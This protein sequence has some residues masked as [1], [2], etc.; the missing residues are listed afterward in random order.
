MLKLY[1]FGGL[2]IE[3]DGRPLQL[4]TQ[5]AGALLAYLAAFR[6]RPHPRSV[7][8]G[9]LWPKVDESKARRRLSDTLWRIRHV[10]GDYVLANDERIWLNLDLPCWLDVEQ[11]QSAV[12]KLKPESSDP[13]L[14]ERALALYRG[15]FLD[16]VY[17]DWAL[18][19]QERLRGLYLEALGHLLTHHKRVGDYT[20][21]LGVARRLV[22]TEPLHETAHRE[23]MRLYH[24]LGRDAEAVAQ[25]RR[26]QE[27]LQQE[28]GVSPAPETEKL[29]RTLSRRAHPPAAAPEAHLPTPALSPAPSLDEPPLVG[30]EAERAALLSRLEAA[31]SGQGGILLLEGEPGVGKSRLAQ[32]LVAGARWRNIEVVLP[33]ADEKTAPAY[34]LLLG[35]LSPLL[36]PLRIRQLTR[37]VEPVHLQALAPLFP[38]LAETLSVSSPLPELPPPQARERI[39]QAL[40]ALVLGL[41]Q[42]KPCLWVLEDV[43]DADA[44]TL[45]LL[46]H[47]LPALKRSRTFVLLTGRSAE[48]RAAPVVWETLQ[49]LDRAGPFPR[50]TLARLDEDAIGRLVRNLLGDEDAILTEHL[51]HESDGV[52]LYLVETLKAWRDEGYLLPGESGTW[53]WSGD[54]PAVPPSHL[55]EAVIAHRLSRLSPASEQVLASAAV[56]GAEVDFDL[57][58]R[59]CAL[60]GRGPDM[61][62]TDP[63][64]LA[65]DELLSLGFLGE[66]NI[67]YRFSHEQVRQAVY[68]SLPPSQ[69]QRLHRRVALAVEE[70]G[71]ERFELLAHHFAAAGQRKPA[72]HY[73]TRAAE[74]ARALFAH[75]NALSCYDRLLDLLTYAEDRAARYDVLCDR[76][77]ALGWIGDREAQGRDL[78]EMLGLARAL[79]D[80]ARLAETLHRR[81]EWRRMQ[82]RYAPANEDALAALEIYRRLG[83]DRAQAALLAQLGW[84]IVYTADRPQAVDYFRQALP[85]YESLGDLAGQVNCLSGLVNAAELDGDYVLAMS[86]L[87]RNLALAEVTQDPIRISRAYHNRGV[88]H[89]DLGDLAAAEADL[90]RAL[91]L[92]ET[93]GDLRSQAITHF[94]L[95]AV[96]AERNDL[97]AAKAHLD[98]ALEIFRDVKDISW[99]GDTLAA[100]GR[101]ALLQGDAKTAEENLRFAGQRCLELGECS[102][103]VIHLSYLAVAELDLE[104]MENA[105]EKSREAVAELDAGL[106]GVERPQRIYYNHYRVAQATRH[107]AA[108][109]AALEE[110]ARIVDERGKRI[111]DPA[112]RETYRTGL[113]ANRA[114]AEAAA[115]LPPPGRLRV[116]LA[117]AD[118]PAHRRPAPEETVTV[119]WSV[120]A[121]EEEAALF[122]REGKV[123]L[124]RHRILRLLDEAQEANAS[125]TVADLAGALDVSPR[126]IRSDLAALREQGHDVRTHGHRA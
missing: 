123:A 104:N 124:R 61:T 32:E 59:V 97:E 102:Y 103:A 62:E 55:G 42:I 105:W 83:D 78:D 100:L 88:I 114:I 116:H 38:P 69:R 44:E 31:A 53:R 96:D 24:L 7:L 90:E 12:S 40:V 73:L 121:G 65:T 54:A 107:W 8:T 25:Y 101:L 79:S 80:D 58:A 48:M 17:H 57:L 81:S 2:R 21:A 26:C 85:I 13:E 34:G 9:L 67:G 20:A 92:K 16:G 51:A 99:E 91:E 82:G 39:Q 119:T 77:E 74:S 98:R 19:E 10:L 37:L 30:R 36:T 115:R 111:D 22:A 64:L 11:F 33:H 75:K 84:N 68:R 76:A 3:L 112:L 94:Y 35:A 87:K 45:S 89:Y 106:L 1:T 122:E 46:P 5:K 14:I 118:A 110:A 27:I 43:Q 72:I 50:C 18:L 70:L 63:Y 28:L 47:L 56:V 49:A 126:T 60:P 41:A 52:P 71:P 125:P 86:H 93:T 6:D 113:R 4:P 95:G 109:R 66:T 15:P 23:L 117:R 120:E 108:A 29:Y